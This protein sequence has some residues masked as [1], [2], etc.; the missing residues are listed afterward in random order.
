MQLVSEADSTFQRLGCGVSQR[1]SQYSH[2]GHW[3]VDLE[4]AVFRYNGS[5]LTKE[6]G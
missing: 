5:Y 1:C 6:L 4:C 3:S 2:E